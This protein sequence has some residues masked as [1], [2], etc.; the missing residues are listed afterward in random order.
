MS[1]EGKRGMSWRGWL[2]LVVALASMAV[3]WTTTVLLLVGLLPTLVTLISERDHEKSA[4]LAMGPLNLWGVMPFVISLWREGQSVSSMRDIVSDPLNLVMMY[5][6]AGIGWAIYRIIPLVVVTV[7]MRQAE[8]N[9]KAQEEYL[10]TLK[11]MWGEDVAG[12]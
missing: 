2:L 10:K 12:D 7:S 11:E 8:V 6:A 3:M 1:H 9:A 5:G 4:T